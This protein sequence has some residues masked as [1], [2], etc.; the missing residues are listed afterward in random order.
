MNPTGAD[1]KTGARPEIPELPVPTVSELSGSKCFRPAMLSGIT[2]GLGILGISHLR[3][4]M[5]QWHKHN[6]YFW[7]P[8]LSL[9]TLFCPIKTIKTDRTFIQSKT[10][11][12]PK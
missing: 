11:D 7:A 2:G 4:C 9:D 8:T 3:G 12:F 6:Y 1:P 10:P 5:W